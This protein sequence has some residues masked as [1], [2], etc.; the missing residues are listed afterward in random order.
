MERLFKL[1]HLSMSVAINHQGSCM[2]ALR[3]WAAASTAQES[4][5]SGGGG[6]AR[7]SGHEWQWAVDGG[8]AAELE[9]AAEEQGEFG[10][11]YCTGHQVRV[12]CFCLL[13]LL[14]FGW[15]RFC[16]ELCHTPP[17]K[18]SN[19]MSI[20]TQRNAPAPAAIA[21][22]TAWCACGTSTRRSHT[23]WAPPRAPRPPPR[24]R[25]AAAA[26]CGP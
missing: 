20:A 11:L 19:T 17:F 22:R 6:G 26:G 23:Y 7:G 1:T 4:S 2:S 25:R 14:P 18:L 24:W 3:E 13:P 21:T 8:R 15:V 5:S 9:A 12:E 10:T 16:A